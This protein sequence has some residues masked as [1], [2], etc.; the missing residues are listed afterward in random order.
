VTASERAAEQIATSH[1]VADSVQPVRTAAFFDLDKTVIAKSS[2]LAFSK[3][4]FAQGLL[5]RRAVLKSTYAQFIFLMSG[6]DHDQMDRMR[7]YLTNMCTGWDVEQVKA[8]VAET[9]HEIVDPLVFAEAANL[10]ADHKL[11]G[12]DVVVVSA[13]GEEI[14]GPIARELGATHSMATRMVVQDGKYT[15]EVGF[16]CYGEGK[17]QAIE[18]LS[19]REGYALE[20]CYAYSDSVTD[21]PML[22]AVGHPSVVN[23]DRGLRKEALAREWPVLTFSRP[24]SL[25]GRISAPSGAAVATTLAVGASALA[26]GALTYSALRRLRF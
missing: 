5:N 9:L 21:L 14:V 7:S 4:F 3:P 6:A 17:V 24:V 12:R 23:P 8:I 11:C 1:P 18:E 26:A 25:R 10:I 19:A 20:H 15:G 13:S 22:R 16:Y 2:T